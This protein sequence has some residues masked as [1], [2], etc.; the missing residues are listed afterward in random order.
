LDK[1]YYLNVRATT[2]LCKEFLANYSSKNGRIVLLSSMQDKEPLTSEVAYAITKAS[3][4][5]IAMTLAPVLDLKGI[6]INAINPGPTDIGLPNANDKNYFKNS[7]WGRL[8]TPT[9]TAN[10][11]SFLVSEEGKW[12]NGQTINS[13]EGLSAI[14][15]E[16]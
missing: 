12:I 11:V 4:P 3:V 15:N 7:T 1:N 10:I 8:G 9:D 5:I 2:L 13:Y 14:I 16:H 6:T